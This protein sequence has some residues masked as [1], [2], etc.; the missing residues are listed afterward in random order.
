MIE[1]LYLH[2]QYFFFIIMNSADYFSA[3]WKETK[4]TLGEGFSFYMCH[5][6]HGKVLIKNVE[7]FMEPLLHIEPL[8]LVSQYEHYITFQLNEL[9]N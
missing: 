9:W 4:I 2:D 3:E 8:R 5:V 7:M 1:L 6:Y